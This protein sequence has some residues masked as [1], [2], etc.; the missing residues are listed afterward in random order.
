MLF[1]DTSSSQPKPFRRVRLQT[2]LR[3][4]VRGR[5]FNRQRGVSH[6]MGWRGGIN[7]GNIN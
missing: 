1:S 5:Q 2:T 6:A 3:Q 4:G 7:R